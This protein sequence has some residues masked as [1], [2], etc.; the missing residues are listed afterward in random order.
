MQMCSQIGSASVGELKTSRLDKR[1]CSPLKSWD[2]R[3]DLRTLHVTEE[4]RKKITLEN[5]PKKFPAAFNLLNKRYIRGRHWILAPLIELESRIYRKKNIK[6]A[7]L[8]DSVGGETAQPENRERHR[9]ET[10]PKTWSVSVPVSYLEP[11][12]L[13]FVFKEAAQI[14]VSEFTVIFCISAQEEGMHLKCT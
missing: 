9:K 3:L 2:C 12:S 14:L 1:L 13:V 11:H 8:K 6:Q 5:I 10:D 7:Q 4:Q